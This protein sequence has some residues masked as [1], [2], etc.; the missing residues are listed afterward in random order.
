MKEWQAIVK[1]KIDITITLINSAPSI[2]P[3]PPGITDVG[4]NALRLACTI[5]E[6]GRDTEAVDCEPKRSSGSQR[7]CC[8]RFTPSWDTRGCEGNRRDCLQFRIFCLVTW[9]WARN[10]DTSG[11]S[12]K[13]QWGKQNHATSQTLHNASSRTKAPLPIY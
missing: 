2:L 7:S 13:G 6:S 9:R 11:E 5:I 8:M 10:R 1:K 4:I 3:A 12:E